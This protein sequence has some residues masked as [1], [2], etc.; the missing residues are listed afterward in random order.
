MTYTASYLEALKIVLDIEG[1]P[2]NHDWDPGGATAYGI[3]KTYWPKYW[4]NGA[5]TLRVA[6][7]FYW[8]EFWNKLGL[9][10]INS[11]ALCLEMFEAGVNC[12]SSNAVKFAQR[13]YNALRKRSWNALVVD[14]AIGPLTL[15]ALNGMCVKYHDALLAGCNYYQ[16]DYY[17]GMN[18]Q[19]KDHALRGWFAKRLTWGNDVNDTQPA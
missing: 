8:N 11:Q 1:R 9:D 4:E 18:E 19:L 16:A 3:A 2:T 6:H 15:G 14:G 12:G 10:K 17:M 13:A 7:E 5:P